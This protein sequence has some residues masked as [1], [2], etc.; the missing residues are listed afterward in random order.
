[1]SD[2]GGECVSVGL[3]GGGGG[4]VPAFVWGQPHH[5]HFRAINLMFVRFAN[6]LGGGGGG[7][8]AR[9][10]TVRAD[11]DQ[12]NKITGPLSRTT[13]LFERAGRKSR[14]EILMFCFISGRR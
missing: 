5:L 12:V 8:G 14:A 2:A 3:R 1:M 6:R 4:G 9:R 11:R 7:G 10:R 13:N